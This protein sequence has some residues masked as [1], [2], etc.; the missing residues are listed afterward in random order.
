MKHA[1]MDPF[2]FIAMVGLICTTNSCAMWSRQRVAPG[3]HHT[4]SAG[5]TLWDIA[6]RYHI[7]IAELM[8]INNVA[9]QQQLQIGRLL[10]IPQTQHEDI[11]LGY[12]GP[13]QKPPPASLPPKKKKQ[14]TRRIAKRAAK[15]RMQ[16][17]PKTRKA[18]SGTKAVVTK[19]SRHKRV[20]AAPTK[21][22]HKPT[23]STR[24]KQPSKQPQWQPQWPVAKPVIL[25]RFD[26]YYGGIAIGSALGSQVVA[27]AAGEVLYAG[28]MGNRYGKIVI[29]KHP[30]KEN[31]TRFITIYAHLNAFT[32]SKQGIVAKGQQ[33]G[34]VGKSGGVSSPRLHFEMRKRR[35]PV[36]PLSYLK[37]PTT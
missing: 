27:A 36:D 5:D 11:F 25:K 21:Q 17:K 20:A 26:P 8:E 29:L 34:T 13:R 9:P 19:R 18:K 35:I 23:T 28:N 1:C 3:S 24:T 32:V 33:I 22:R 10:Y 14:T 30:P 2:L 15:R 7:P 4:V 12:N 31:P 16:T 37:P 6:Q